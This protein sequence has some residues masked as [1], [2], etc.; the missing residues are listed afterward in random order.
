MAVF[1]KVFKFTSPEH[2]KKIEPVAI[3]ALVKD[4]GFGQEVDDLRTAMRTDGIDIDGRFLDAGTLGMVFRTASTHTGQEIPEAVTR[5]EYVGM[6]LNNPIVLRPVFAKEYPSTLGGYQVCVVPYAPD[7]EGQEVTNQDIVRTIRVLKAQGKELHLVDIGKKQFVF[8]RRPDGDLL[9]YP[10]DTSDPDFRNQPIAFV[11]D[12]N[13]VLADGNE[14]RKF[15]GT[16]HTEEALK[17][18]GIDLTQLLPAPPECADAC[19]QQYAITHRLASALKEAGIEPNMPV[20]GD[21]RQ[22]ERLPVAKSGAASLRR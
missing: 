10:P 3:D 16:R 11:R 1:D 6:P 5:I 13:A 19:E 20:P 15:R 2:I 18:M 21:H 9:R 17:E 12:L 22:V 14:A 7:V 4:L 8:L